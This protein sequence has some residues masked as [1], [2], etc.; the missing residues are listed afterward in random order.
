MKHIT[1]FTYLV[2]PDPRGHI[3]IKKNHIPH[4]A[5]QRVSHVQKLLDWHMT[6]VLFL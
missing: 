3:S 1:H 2:N 5:S 4:F 6:Q